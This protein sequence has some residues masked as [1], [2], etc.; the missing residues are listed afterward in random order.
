[1]AGVRAHALDAASGAAK[2]IDNILTGIFL[3]MAIFAA[4][5]IVTD[6]WM[7]RK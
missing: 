7:E 6:W 5:M 4:I 1:M 3:G 2:M